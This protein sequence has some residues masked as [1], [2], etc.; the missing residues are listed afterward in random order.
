VVAQQQSDEHLEHEA[1]RWPVAALP[2]SSAAAI[3]AASVFTIAVAVTILTVRLI[4]DLT[5]KPLFEDEG[6]A[7]TIAARPLTEILRTAVWE[8]GGAPAHFVLAHLALAVDSSSVALR[9]VSVLFALLTVG[10][11]F[12]LGR[13]LGGETAAVVAAAAT[14]TSVLLTIYGTFGRM[15]SMFAFAG[16]LAADLFIRAVRRR[17]AG[18][19]FAAAA[20]AWLLPAVHPFGGILV[21]FEALAGIC[22]WRGRNVRAALPV[23]AVALATVPFAIGDLRL[24][25]RFSTGVVEASPLLTPGKAAQEVVQ[26]IL[27]F[28]GGITL[29]ALILV[30]LAIGGACVAIR[31]EPAIAAVSVIPLLALP[32][33]QTVVRVSGGAGA[34]SVR[35]L[36]FALPI[37]CAFIGVAVS[38]LVPPQRAAMTAGVFLAVLG[39][40]A[41]GGLAR[42]N[43]DVLDPRAD[44]LWAQSGTDAALRAPANWLRAR[45]RHEDVLFPYST[46]YLAAFPQTASVPAV[47]RD[48]PATIIA[49]LKHVRTPIR[50]VFVAAPVP[51]AE[52]DARALRRRIGS[53][54]R[55]ASFRWWTLVEARGPFVSRRE[56]LTEID[57]VIRAMRGAARA[58][59][60]ELRLFLRLTEAN[61]CV[62]LAGSSRDCATR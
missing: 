53:D 41:A 59:S 61:V 52:L 23:F 19:A 31:R 40:G 62:A 18:A 11:A 13:R 14:A 60:A 37:W 15:Y 21:A 51:A 12:D 29:A 26:A 50:R 24:G 28:A 1:R 38:R 44:V 35:H 45:V 20:A 46:V 4:T 56:A 22:L 6:L 47:P 25:T 36:I 5:T 10:V 7:G 30:P 43:D 34:P 49:A 3:R 48:P 8:R 42:N 39:L 9:L 27:G 17:T 32:S 33:L 2:L 58:P 57:R 55:V 16:G 54:S